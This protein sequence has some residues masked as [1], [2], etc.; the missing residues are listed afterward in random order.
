MGNALDH[1]SPQLFYSFARYPT[2]HADFRQ[3]VDH[4]DSKDFKVEVCSIGLDVGYCNQ[5]FDEVLAG[6][7]ERF[8]AL[9]AALPSLEKLV[10]AFKTTDQLSSFVEAVLK[11][12]LAKIRT[13]FRPRLVLQHHVEEEFTPWRQQYYVYADL[14]GVAGAATSHLTY[15]RQRC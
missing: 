3:T 9:L 1:L 12:K 14:E 10:I 13:R 2:H 11:P 5:T 8:D 7:W 15:S 6:D 4:G